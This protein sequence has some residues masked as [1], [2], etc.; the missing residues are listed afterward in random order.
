MALA[1]LCVAVVTFADPPVSRAPPLPPGLSAVWRIDGRKL[2]ANASAWS[3]AAFSTDGALVGVS[4]ETGTRVYRAGDGMLVRQL[5][6]PFATGQSAFS[7]AISVT[8]QVAIGRVGGVDLY[9]AARG[10]EPRRYYCAGACGP[11]SAL[12]F[13]PDGRW[14]AFQAARGVLEPVPG[15]VTVVDLR[16]NTPPLSLEAS[17]T[18]TH[19]RFARDGAS[20]DAANVLR[21]DDSGLFGVRTW[22]ATAG[23]RR[24]RDVPGALVPRGAVGPFAL[25]DRLAAYQRAGRL[26]LRELATGALVWTV[27]L[28]PALDAAGSAMKLDLVAFA[29]NGELALSYETP[30]AGASPGAL[31]LRRIRDG[32][33]V[34]MYDVA[35]VTALAIAPDAGS[36]VYTAGVG[37]TYATLARV[38]R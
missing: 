21:L 38:P 10:D 22:T 8:G 3:V 33:T 11:V 32:A 1:L 15:L 24:V 25:S 16:T 29:P 20:L 27:P 6:P 28:A 7:L 19:V 2:P 26:E 13:S 9:S 14:L 17:A 36:F 12:A 31:V 37:R 30:T 18:R 5:S 23:W 34:A 35:A 4:D